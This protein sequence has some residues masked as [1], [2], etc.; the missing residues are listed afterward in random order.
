MLTPSA[1]TLN[2]IIN[3]A[4]GD[5]Q[6]SILYRSATD[7]TFLPPGTAGNFLSTGGPGANPVW[8]P[9]TGTGNVSNVGTGTGLTGGP[10]TSTGTISIA[11][12]TANT[13]AGY[14]NSGVFS[15][16]A[17]GSGLSLS[18]GTL[19][20]SGGGAVSSVANSDGTLTVSP[21]TGSVVVSLA[22]LTSSKV[23]VGNGSNIATG[24]SVSGDATLANTGALTLSTVNS[25]NGAFGCSK[26]IPSFTVNS[27]GLITAASTNVVIAPA[28]TLTGTTFS[29]QM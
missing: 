10:I 23:L 27:K 17:I 22:A 7:W 13:L 20:A 24:V 5:I 3:S 21:T 25:N 1:N 9:E 18:G 8:L 12:S 28:G 26:A 2:N 11:N 19:S 6:G 29:L 15:D 4:I 16:V 14:N